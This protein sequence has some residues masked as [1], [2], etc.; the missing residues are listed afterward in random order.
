[1][2]SFAGDPRFERLVAVLVPLLRRSCPPGGGVFGGSYELR[3]GVDE[4]EELGGVA[5]IRSAMRQAGRALG[6]A[7]LQTFG[8]SFP[9]VAVAGV[10]DRREVPA[11]FAAAVEEYELQRGRAAAEVVGQTLEGGKPRAVP[12]SVLVMAQEFRV[13]YAEGVAG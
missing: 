9:Q 11:E 6:W 5:L 8:G 2:P 1:M 12:G 3:L 13:A 10:V 4:A 7:K